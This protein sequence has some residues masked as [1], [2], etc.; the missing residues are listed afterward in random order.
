MRKV[1]IIAAIALVGFIVA[2]NL[3]Y[4]DIGLKT[5]EW[6]KKL[7]GQNVRIVELNTTTSKTINHD[8]WT[9]LLST[10]VTKDG[11]VNYEGFA[12]E[13]IQLQTYLDLISN[14]PP[15][16]N[17]T[18]EYKMAFWINSYNAYT[19]K[20]ILDHY[21]LESIKKI[22][23]GLPMINSPWDI[24]FFKI[25]GIPFDLNTIEHE[26]LRKKFSDPRIHFAI[27][28]ASISCPKLLNEAFNPLKIESQLQEQTHYFINN[29]TKNKIDKT[30]LKL[31][32]IFEWFATDFKASKGTVKK[33]IQ[34]YTDMDIANIKTSYLTYDWKLNKQ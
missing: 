12:E 10:H 32:R 25:G 29:P 24:K 5:L 30:E 27:N 31:S 20:L 18:E 28:C 2:I 22:S 7:R 26:I 34:E 16:D 11:F 15:K 9:N 13:S 4:H 6:I 8:S 19:V 3:D 21:P 23:D 1:L 33:F 14:N 17:Q